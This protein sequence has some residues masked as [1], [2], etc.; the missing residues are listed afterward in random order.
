MLCMEAPLV[1]AHCSCVVGMSS[2]WQTKSPLFRLKQRLMQRA[3][4]MEERREG[5]KHCEA[6]VKKAKGPAHD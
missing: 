1:R 3:E 6:M 2:D 4:D 5:E